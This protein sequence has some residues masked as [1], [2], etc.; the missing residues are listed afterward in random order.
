MLASIIISTYNSPLWLEKVLIGFSIQTNQDFEIL[1]AD[2]GSTAETKTLIEKYQPIFKSLKHIW[3][4]DNGFQKCQILNKAILASTS[5]Y[6]IFTDGDCIPRKD[7]VAVHLQNRRENCFL[8]GGYFKLP[9]DISQLI[10]LADI[11]MQHCFDVS[12]LKENGLNNSFK[13]SKLS[14]NTTV[15]SFLNEFTTTKPT[16]NGHNASGWRKD[17]VAVNG[18][19]ERMKYGGEDRELG[20]RLMNNGLRGLQVRYKAIC[21]HLDHARSYVND[22]D[23]ANNKSIREQTKMNKSVWTDF[24]LTP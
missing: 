2:D 19:D 9:M 3:H 13:N 7:F 18:F 24:G 17:I 15:T 20:E 10:S 12:W 16:W 8:S 11:Q 4:P 21:I 14:K 22:T 6:L 5:P 23:L 1:I